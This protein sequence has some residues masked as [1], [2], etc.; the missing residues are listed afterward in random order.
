MLVLFNKLR[1]LFQP[2]VS[3]LQ[4]S[5]GI[6]LTIH[7]RFEFTEILGDKFAKDLTQYLLFSTELDMFFKFKFWVIWL[8]NSFWISAFLCHAQVSII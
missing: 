6:W 7:D 1:D 4:S 8:D 3:Y 5:E 2:H